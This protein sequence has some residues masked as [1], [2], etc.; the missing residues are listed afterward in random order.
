[1]ARAMSS[2]V[3]AREQTPHRIV[4]LV[5]PRPPRE[6]SPN[7]RC[8]WRPRSRISKTYKAAVH[9]LALQAGLQHERWDGIEVTPTF[10]F[11]R[12][13]PAGQRRDLDNLAAS[14]KTAY[15]AIALTGVIANDHS[16]IPMPAAEFVGAERDEVHLVI[17]PLTAAEVLCRRRGSL[18]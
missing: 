11:V 4:R 6:L 1:M 18:A 14:L 15:D 13:P 8:H 9:Y 16:L 12:N 3:P 5:I 2:Q 7:G 10:H 17:R